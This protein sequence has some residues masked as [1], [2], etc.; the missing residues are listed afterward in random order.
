MLIDWKYVASHRLAAD[1]GWR[2]AARYYRYRLKVTCLLSALPVYVF[3]L[4]LGV[5]SSI[6]QRTYVAF[7][8][9]TA[10]V[11]T[12][13]VL[14]Y[15]VKW[16]FYTVRLRR[17]AMRDDDENPLFVLNPYVT[18]P[19]LRELLA[20]VLAR[21]ALRAAALE[22][23]ARCKYLWGKRKYVNAQRRRGGDWHQEHMDQPV[24]QPANAERVEPEQD[25][26]APGRS[27]TR[28]RSPRKS[29][30]RKR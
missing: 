28:K 2:H 13:V 5:V 8:S 1:R 10:L 19:S 15:A 7:A 4:Y 24:D 27:T 30:T 22:R 18:E 26:T 23:R 12:L 29:T 20:P 3:L 21:E 17:D 14:V 6:Q 25:P 11:V 16:W 9:A